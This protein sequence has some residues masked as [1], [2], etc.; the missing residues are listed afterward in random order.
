M[1]S[2]KRRGC[3]GIGADES[4]SSNDAADESAS[5]NGATE[6]RGDPRDDAPQLYMVEDNGWGGD[7]GWKRKA[8]EN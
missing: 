7:D 5:S 8:E 3:F 1:I 6:P 2:K 4:A